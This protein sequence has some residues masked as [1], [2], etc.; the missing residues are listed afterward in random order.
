MGGQYYLLVALEA[1]WAV[2]QSLAV[3]VHHPGPVTRVRGE[4]LAGAQAIQ[5]H[6]GATQ[7]AVRTE[8]L[9]TSERRLT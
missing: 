2:P 8:C 7:H 4:G 3:Q 5:Q 6:R 9:L 1:G